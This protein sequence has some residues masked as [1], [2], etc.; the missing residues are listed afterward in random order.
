M[1]WWHVEHDGFHR[2]WEEANKAAKAKP[3]ARSKLMWALESLH[4]LHRLRPGPAAGPEEF[5]TECRNPP[6]G[7]LFF[8]VTRG[9][10]SRM[11]HICRE[12]H[13]LPAQA[14]GVI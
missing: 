3:L 8:T 11:Q 12:F 2:Q 9:K 7:T 13:L 5:E 4:E 10:F 1:I 6:F 14:K